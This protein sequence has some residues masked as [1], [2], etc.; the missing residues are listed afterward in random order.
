MYYD[1]LRIKL[2]EYWLVKKYLSFLYRIPEICILF[3][4]N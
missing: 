2:K 4:I 3:E 1:N